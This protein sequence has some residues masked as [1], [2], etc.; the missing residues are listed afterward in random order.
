MTTL[1]PNAFDVAPLHE[2]KETCG[3]VKVY[4]PA[5]RLD[6]AREVDEAMAR[7]RR[8]DHPGRVLSVVVSGPGAGGEAYGSNAIRVVVP[9]YRENAEAY[10]LAGAK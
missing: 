4:D 3:A 10:Y 2:T 9:G 5:G 6:G 1:C 7:Q 8:N